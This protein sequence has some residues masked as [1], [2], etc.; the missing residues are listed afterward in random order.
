MAL[1]WRRLMFT[2]EEEL[3][4][5]FIATME[6]AYIRRELDDEWLWKIGI[7]KAYSVNSA[8]DFLVSQSLMVNQPIELSF[9]FNN[10]WSGCVLSKVLAFSWQL[11]QDR[12]PTRLNLF[13]RNVLN[14]I[15]QCTCVLCG[16]AEESSSHPFHSCPFT[17]Q[18][19]K[20]MYRWLGLDLVMPQ[21]IE[22]HYLLHIDFFKKKNVRRYGSL[23]WHATTWRIWLQRNAI[24]LKNESPLLPSFLELIKHGSQ[25]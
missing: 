2:W 1:N 11:L 6:G 10:F 9:L 23:F 5:M 24:I 19:W 20:W 7:S 3:L 25:Q 14:D 4:E 15:H 8:Y 16:Q 17:V 18:V 21:D 22:T 13:R 12:I